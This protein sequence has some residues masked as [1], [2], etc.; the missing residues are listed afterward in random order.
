MRPPLWGGSSAGSGARSASLRSTVCKAASA[1]SGFTASA[2]G[3]HTAWIVWPGDEAVPGKKTPQTC[4]MK[5]GP[6][7]PLAHRVAADQGLE[8]FLHGTALE[9]NPSHNVLSKDMD[10]EEAN[11]LPGE[12]T[13][14]G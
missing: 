5:W 9:S 14:F 1:S 13:G 6:G 4:F 12:A 7:G 8:P 11:F 2:A 3:S 10:S